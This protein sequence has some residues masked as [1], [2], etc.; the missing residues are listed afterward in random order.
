MKWL[1]SPVL[2]QNRDTMGL[3]VRL[4]TFLQ[5]VCS[6]TGN[7]STNHYL[8]ITSIYLAVVFVLSMLV[9]AI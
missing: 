7:L 6:N 2:Q 3:Y 5:P 4:A 9:I 1:I 8:L